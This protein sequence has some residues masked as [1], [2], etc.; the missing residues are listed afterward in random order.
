MHHLKSHQG[1]V[2][3]RYRKMSALQRQAL[4]YWNR[5]DQDQLPNL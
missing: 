1:N 4:F 5:N 2:N 3:E